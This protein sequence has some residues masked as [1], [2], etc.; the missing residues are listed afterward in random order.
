M[1]K[2][3]FQAYTLIP[4]SD[5]P[6]YVSMIMDDVMKEILKSPLGYATLRMKDVMKDSKDIIQLEKLSDIMK[7]ARVWMDTQEEIE[8]TSNP[9]LFKATGKEELFLKALRRYMSYYMECIDGWGDVLGSSIKDEDPHA[10]AAFVEAFQIILFV[11]PL[12]MS[13]V[14]IDLNHLYQKA[15][16]PQIE[17]DGWMYVAP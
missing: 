7:K 16:D 10:F 6:Y 15:I 13:A 9:W 5:F 4:M 1:T 17:G 11:P 14:E 12:M 3:P 8:D 2:D